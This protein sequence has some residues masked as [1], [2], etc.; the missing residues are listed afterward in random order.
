MIDDRLNRPGRQIGDRCQLTVS[1]WLHGSVEGV[2]DRI[3]IDGPS[4]LGDVKKVLP[5]KLLQTGQGE[6]A[7]GDGVRPV[8]LGEQTSQVLHPEGQLVALQ[9]D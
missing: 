9:L 6:L 5:G 2:L 4:H 1:A 8:I 7:R 3:E